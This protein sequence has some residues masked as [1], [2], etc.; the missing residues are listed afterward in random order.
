VA[1]ACSVSP[2][3]REL[4]AREYTALHEGLRLREIT[5]DR[6]E[7]PGP[8]TA[9][10]VATEIQYEKRIP[11]ET[12][13]FH[14]PW[15]FYAQPT[16]GVDAKG[17]LHF[18]SGRYE[19]RRRG[20]E[21][22]VP[23]DK[24]GSPYL[25]TKHVKAERWIEA[26]PSRLTTLGKLRFIRYKRVGLDGPTRT[27]YLRFAP[28]DA[29]VIAHD[30]HGNLHV[31]GGRYRIN[32]DSLHGAETPMARR[33]H[34]HSRRHVRSNPSRGSSR[35]SYGRYIE[36][37]GKIAL[38]SLGVLAMAAPVAVLVDSAMVRTNISGGWRVASKLAI[39]IIGK[40]LIELMP[41]SAFQRAVGD[42]VLYGAGVDG[43]L[44][45]WNLA[46]APYLAQLMAPSATP[47]TT[48]TQTNSA[49]G[50]RLPAGAARGYQAFNPQACAVGAR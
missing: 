50:V 4:M 11:G 49:A 44:D 48:Q 37:Q 9:F 14:H 21:D 28:G 47:T 46:V 23:A 33:R 25:V 31:L 18:K 3:K 15:K 29:P 45:G 36:E 1:S 19:V 32:V 40:G 42:A 2:A 8:R 16:L 7:H 34:R 43:A 38:G 30:E 12:P 41:P 24:R 22:R 35:R 6:L 20:I 39:A 10:A 13:D 26:P 17:H 5:C 27:G